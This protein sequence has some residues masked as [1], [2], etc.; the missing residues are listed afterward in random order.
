MLTNLRTHSKSIFW[1]AG[2]AVALILSFL[3][4]AHL[5]QDHQDHHLIVQVLQY[6]IMRGKLDPLPAPVPLPPAAAA[7]PPAASSAPKPEKP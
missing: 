1:G 5:W 2:T 7:T 6:N 4:A 3:L